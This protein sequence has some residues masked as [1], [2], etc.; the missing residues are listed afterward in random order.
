MV[1]HLK[2]ISCSLTEL[3]QL[4]CC[5]FSSKHCKRANYTQPLIFYVYVY[6]LPNTFLKVKGYSISVIKYG[7]TSVSK[8]PRLLVHYE[9]GLLYYEVGQ[10]DY[11]VGVVHYEVGPVHYGVGPG[12]KEALDRPNNE[13]DRPHNELDRPYNQLDRPHN[14]LDRPHNKLDRPHNELDRPHNQ[15]DRPHNELANFDSVMTH[16]WRHIIVKITSYE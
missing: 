10:V 11:E 4:L 3:R 15:L 16:T 9:V 14:Q 13:L 6:F 5:F 2:Q 7:D 1:A 12:P 8:L